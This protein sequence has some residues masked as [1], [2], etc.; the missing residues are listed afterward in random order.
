MALLTADVSDRGIERIMWVVSPAKLAA[1]V[2]S[3]SGTWT[4]LGSV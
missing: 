2:A 3:V 1:Y 4:V